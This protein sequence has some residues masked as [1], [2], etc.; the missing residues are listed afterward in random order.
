VKVSYY[1]QSTV[2]YNL[3]THVQVPRSPCGDVGVSLI[4]SDPPW[5]AY[6]P[7]DFVQ[8]HIR[9]IYRCCDGTSLISMAFVD[10]IKP[11]LLWLGQNLHTISQVDVM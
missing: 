11:G 9:A 6:P 1:G 4:S 5:V 8:E 7:I 3:V 2:H 10:S